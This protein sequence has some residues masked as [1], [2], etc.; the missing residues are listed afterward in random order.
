MLLTIFS[1]IYDELKLKRTA[2]AKQAFEALDSEQ[3]TNI[4]TERNTFWFEYPLLSNISNKTHDWLV[5][6]IE[7]K[8]Y[9]YLYSEA[10]V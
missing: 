5:Q 8:G 3:I 7:N 2:I 9:H 6:Y 4:I 1:T 10:V